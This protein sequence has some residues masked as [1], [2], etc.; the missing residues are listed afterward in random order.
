MMICSSS[1]HRYLPVFPLTDAW[2]QE[3]AHGCHVPQVPEGTEMTFLSCL[4]VS[5]VPAAARPSRERNACAVPV[6]TRFCVLS[7]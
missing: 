3:E 6:F 7:L 1:H 4:P 2:G 5:A